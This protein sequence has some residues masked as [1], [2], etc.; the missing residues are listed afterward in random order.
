MV[1]MQMANKLTIPHFFV[2]HTYTK[3]TKCH[4]CNHVLVRVF[5]QGLQYKDC[6]YNAHKKCFKR[7]PRDCTGEV[8]SG[9]GDGRKS[10]VSDADD[11]TVVTFSNFDFTWQLKQ[12]TATFQ[13]SD[14][15]RV[16]NRQKGSAARQSRRAGWCTLPTRT[17]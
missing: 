15:F 7:V 4:F 6:R 5:K 2:L 12:H 9:G 3:L 13:S 16:S 11:A 1:A 17:I 10:E 14:L 8:P